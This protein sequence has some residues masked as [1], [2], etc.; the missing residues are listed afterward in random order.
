MASEAGH[1]EIVQLLLLDDRVDPSAC[2]S[3]AL[4]LASETGPFDAILL[5]RHQPK[6]TLALLI[7]A[8]QLEA[9]IRTKAGGV[10]LYNGIVVSIVLD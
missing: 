4:R 3:G 2:D 1:L 6:E 9:L 8:D 10:Y 7:F 5:S